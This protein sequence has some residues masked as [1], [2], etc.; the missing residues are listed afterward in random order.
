[1]LKEGIIYHGKGNLKENLRVVIISDSLQS[2]YI[3]ICNYTTSK[4]S[5]E[6]KGKRDFLN[7]LQ[8]LF[9]PPLF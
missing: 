8:I 3:I 7:N 9:L 2:S 6:I 4:R 1:M 5:L